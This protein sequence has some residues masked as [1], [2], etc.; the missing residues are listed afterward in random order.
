MAKY[1]QGGGCACGLYKECQEKWICEGRWEG[2]KKITVGWLPLDKDNEPYRPEL[3]R[4]RHKRTKPVTLYQTESRAKT[5]S[6]IN[7]AVEV[8]YENSHS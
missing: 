8:F 6:P 5:Y 7:K 3:G 1:D 2:E 4:G